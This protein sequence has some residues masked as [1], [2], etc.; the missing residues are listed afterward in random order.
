L[1]CK[2]KSRPAVKKRKIEKRK[3]EKEKPQLRSVSREYDCVGIELRTSRKKRKQRQEPRPGPKVIISTLPYEPFVKR[4]N[5]CQH[6][7]G[8]KFPH[9]PVIC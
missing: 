6:S 7:M 5:V 8:L 4:K 9:I 2:G 1:G 3:E